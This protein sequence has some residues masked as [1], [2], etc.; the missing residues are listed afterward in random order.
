MGNNKNNKE[1]I[2][3][4]DAIDMEALVKYALEEGFDPGLFAELE[5]D[6]PD[7]DNDEPISLELTQE[8]DAIVAELATEAGAIK[9][10]TIVLEDEAPEAEASDEPDAEPE[11]TEE[12]AQTEEPV[13]EETEEAPEEEKSEEP[14]EEH[15]GEPES[16]HPVEE[17]KKKSSFKER[18]KK[19][20]YK[21]RIA[22]ILAIELIIVGAL[23]DNI[24]L[25]V[26][27]TQQLERQQIAAEEAANIVATNMLP[28]IPSSTKKIEKTGTK[29][30]NE[31]WIESIKD[32][33]ANLEYIEQER[34][35]DIENSETYKLVQGAYEWNGSK[36]SRSA[37]TV[38][39]PNG[40][41][42]YYNLNMSVIVRM[43]HARGV[44]DT[45][46]VRSDGCKMLGN[47]IMVAADLDLH[48]RGSIVK[49][50]KG[51]AMVCDTGSFT[52]HNRHQID[53]AVNW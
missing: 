21:K 16:G 28:V 30:I 26:E 36:L 46:W 35:T 44:N 15:T 31:K 17:S 43:M 48:P 2:V 20:P 10:E 25:K 13:S 37:G 47:Y 38:T 6:F 14:V 7:E 42:T 32:K 8:I 4:V 40:K 34:D 50:S 5:A 18:F 11:V 29:K 53:V 23:G 24:F 12:E 22:A 41:E 51:L 1:R 39:G 3:H 45:Y 19:F 9:E 27:N 33:A 49:T 52:K